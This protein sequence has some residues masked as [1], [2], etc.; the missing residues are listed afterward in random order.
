MNRSD[1]PAG[2]STYGKGTKK[3]G[4]TNG[5]PTA[6][7]NGAYCPTEDYTKGV[8]MV[9]IYPNATPARVDVYW[10]H[11]AGDKKNQYI[12]GSSSSNIP[13]TSG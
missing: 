12:G 6:N 8:V 2:S 4:G 7:P 13:T 3:D 1:L 5:I 10:K 11:N 9:S